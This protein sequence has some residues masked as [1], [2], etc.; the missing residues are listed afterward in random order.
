MSCQD[1]G[2][3]NDINSTD[4]TPL[5]IPVMSIVAGD[6]FVVFLDS[7]PQVVLPDK[8]LELSSQPIFVCSHRSQK[9]FR[10]RGRL[11]VI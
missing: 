11:W 7:G 5:C 10:G 4:V 2:V 9:L 3:R 8:N 1:M 6:P